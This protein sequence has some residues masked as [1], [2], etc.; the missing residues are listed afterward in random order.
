MA[1]AV[2]KTPVLLLDHVNLNAGDDW[3]PEL[4]A[5][6]F[7]TLGCV[8]DPR[9]EGVSQRIRAS[10]GQQTGL[11]WVNIGLQQFHMPLGEPEDTTQGML[12]GV[13]GL[14]FP[15]LQELA[16]RLA[17]ANVAFEEAQE[18]K[19]GRASGL[20]FCGRALKIQTPTGV[21][22]RLHQAS[23]WCAPESAAKFS[24]AQPGGKSWGLGMPYIE[25]LCE[26]GAAAGIARFYQQ[27]LGIPMEEAG[28]ACRMLMQTGQFLLFSET[29]E[30]IA[31]YDNHH[32]AIYIGSIE[33]SDISETF[34][35]MY[36]QCKN[37]G[38]V[39]NN[40]R[41]PN[42]VYDSLEDAQRQG[43]FRILDMVDPQDGRVV[44][45]LEHEIRSLRHPGFP[46][47][48]MLAEKAV[49]LMSED[50]DKLKLLRGA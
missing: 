40:P 17:E 38:M 6:W 25:F 16:K 11:R 13:V 47:K 41:F 20:R 27:T 29:Q 9:A 24:V 19:E 23:S 26:P 30:P 10:G 42:M 2:A 1:E 4:D 34:S 45:R 3:T 49:P 32:I 12:N 22:L 37:A 8:S 18:E 7:G 35:S 14:A 44:F 46:C 31:A 43:E 15:D 50:R 5:F 28:G 39:W 48:Q 21:H 33:N 36:I